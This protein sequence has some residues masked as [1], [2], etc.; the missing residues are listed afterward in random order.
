MII[1]DTHMHI[2]PGVDDGSSSLEESIR[3]LQMSAKQGVGMVIATPHSWGIENYGVK[4]VLSRFEQLKNAVIARKIPIRLYLGCEMLVKMEK[5]PSWMYLNGKY[6]VYEDTVNDCIRKLDNC[7][8]PTMAGTNYVLTEFDE[9]ELE[10]NMGPCIQKLISAGYIPIIAHVERY[11]KITMTGVRELKTFGAKIQINAYSISS[12]TNVHTRQ[13]ANDCLSERLVDFI[14]SDAHRLGHRPPIIADGV[15]AMIRLYTEEY[16]GK[17][18]E[19][20][21][22]DL[23][24]RV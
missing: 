9:Q 5:D 17:V 3:M 20:N 19:D 8:Y 14:G 2:I 4:H 10:G 18:L 6:F 12:E 16:A 21:P 24:L 7:S 11:R 22:R 15:D 1:I 23:L 13:L